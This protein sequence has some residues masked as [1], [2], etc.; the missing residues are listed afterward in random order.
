ME[1]NRVFLGLELINGVSFT[2][3]YWIDSNVFNNGAIGTE[4]IKEIINYELSMLK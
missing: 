3:L 2:Q 1:G 4:D